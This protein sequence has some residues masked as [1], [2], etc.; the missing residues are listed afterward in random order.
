MGEWGIWIVF[1]SLPYMVVLGGGTF[2]KKAV[3]L[4]LKFQTIIFLDSWRLFYN[5]SS[6]AISLCL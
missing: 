3:P 2:D 5:F 1:V 6:R 4:P